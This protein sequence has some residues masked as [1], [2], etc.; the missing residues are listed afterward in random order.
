VAGGAIIII[1]LF[2]CLLGPVLMYGSES[3]RLSRSNEESLRV[4]EEYF[5]QC[6]K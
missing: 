4:F 3:W 1:Q 2:M 5:A 6:E